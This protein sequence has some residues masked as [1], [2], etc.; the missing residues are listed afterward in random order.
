MEGTDMTH[1]RRWMGLAVAVGSVTLAVAVCAIWL[2]LSRP[3]AVAESLQQG[4]V[5]PAVRALAAMLADA[6]WALA[7]WL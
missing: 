4:S 3:V 6:W 1:E 2:A 5:T 7:R